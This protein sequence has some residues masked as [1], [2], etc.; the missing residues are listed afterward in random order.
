MRSTEDW[1]SDFNANVPVAE[2]CRFVHAAKR[3]VECDGPHIRCIEHILHRHE[4]FN[5]QPLP[6][7]RILGAQVEL[8]V[9]PSPD[10][11]Q[12]AIIGEHIGLERVVHIKVEPL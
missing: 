6:L 5:A 4:G 10:G 8:S 3:P 1:C 9:A 11:H 12:V 2:R 7:R